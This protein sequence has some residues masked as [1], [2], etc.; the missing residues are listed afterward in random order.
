MVWLTESRF[1]FGLQCHKR[2][3]FEIHQPLEVSVE[4]S[5]AIV[6]GRA[7]D[8]VV[9]RLDP[10]VVISRSWIGIKRGLLDDTLVPLNADLGQNNDP[11]VGQRGK[12]L[13]A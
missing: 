6:Q 12:H 8:D 2:L 3:W 1:L 9:Q 4:P 5:I 7:F 13:D 10:G 11:E